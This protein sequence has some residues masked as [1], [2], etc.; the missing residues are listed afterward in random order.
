MPG[1]AHCGPRALSS[2]SR[3]VESAVDCPPHGAVSLTDRGSPGASGDLKQILAGGAPERELRRRLRWLGTM[4]AEMPQIHAVSWDDDP[5]A[6][7]GYEYPTPAIDPALQPLLSRSVGRV[8]FAGSH[9]S[10]RFQG[11]MN[12]AVESGQRAARELESLAP[13]LDR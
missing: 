2:R 8:F 5:W 12:G 10:A 13:V 6:Q 7:G 4:P 1:Q 9:T 11:Y 3:H